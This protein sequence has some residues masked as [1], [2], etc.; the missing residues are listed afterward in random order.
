[1][2]VYTRGV[3]EGLMIG[4]TVQVNVLEV[5]A[6]CVRL[7]IIDPDASPTY[8]EEILYLTSDADDCSIDQSLTCGAFDDGFSFEDEDSRLIPMA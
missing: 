3:D 2:R 7:A 8:R 4:E 1:M 5:Q 6:N